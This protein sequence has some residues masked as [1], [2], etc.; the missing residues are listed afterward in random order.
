MERY[1]SAKMPTTRKTPTA[2]L[3]RD[4][5]INAPSR[6]LRGLGFT[7][8]ELAH[9]AILRRLDGRRRAELH[10]TPL[11]QHAH[12]IGDL[13]DL[14]DLVTHHD[15]REPVPPVQVGDQ[16]VDRVHEDGIEAGGGLVEE[17]DLR[18]GHQRARDGHALAHAA[19]YL[20]RI[21]RLH[22][23]EPD[24]AERGIDALDDLRAGQAQLLAQG[25]GH[26]LTARHGVEQ[27]AALEDDAVTPPDIV[28]RAPAEPRHVHV[29]DEDAAGVG[30]EEPDEVTQEHRLAAAAAPDDDGDGA[31]GDLQIK[32]AQHRVVAERLPEAF[33]LDHEGAALTAAPCRGSSPR[34]G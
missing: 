33:D 9:D 5:S 30:S 20:G 32:A 15:G 16:L 13:E 17:D 7:A 1:P 21:F 10:D 14:G 22:A 6:S 12:E 3:T 28:E 24:L 27:R 19:G 25:E 4:R 29:V 18:L 34:R 26:V 2:M 31:G 11:V 23:L 8:A